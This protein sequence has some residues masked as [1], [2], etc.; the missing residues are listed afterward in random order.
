MLLLG[1]FVARRGAAAAH[2]LMPLRIYRSR[3][4]S[5]SNLVV[6]LIGAATFAMWFFL[7]LYLQ[8]VRGYSAI[9]AGL[10]FLPMTLC[11]VAGSTLGLAPGHPRGHQA[12]ARRRACSP[13]PSGW[14]GSHSSRRPAATLGA[15]ARALA[16]RR[17]RAS[18]SSF[19]PVT[20]SAV[21]GVRARGGRPGLGPGQHL[22][23][24]RWRARPGRA[25]RAGHG[26]HQPRTRPRGRRP[27]RS[28]TAALTSGFQLAFGVAGAI[29]L[30]GALVALGGLPALRE[31]QHR[32]VVVESAERHLSRAAIRRRQTSRR[33][34]RWPLGERDHQAGGEHDHRAPHDRVGDQL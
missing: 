20:I 3:T 33:V 32:A 25:G 34:Q 21:A 19:V 2:P 12:A 30:V 22:A 27:P 10:T 13:R 23:A 26:A 6:L 18:G 16:A 31:V 14:P 7:S 15:A 28:C 24:V 4:L 8:Q 9:H 1:A 11:I 17:D 5:A 29:S